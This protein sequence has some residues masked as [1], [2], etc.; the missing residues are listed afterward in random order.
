M[1]CIECMSADYCDRCSRSV[2][3]CQSVSLSLCLSRPCAWKTAKRSQVLVLNGSPDPTTARGGGWECYILPSAAVGLVYNSLWLLSKRV[4]SIFFSSNCVQYACGIMVFIIMSTYSLN[5]IKK[6]VFCIHHSKL[7]NA[8][9]DYNP[10]KFH[11]I[12][13]HLGSIEIQYK[14]FVGCFIE[15]VYT[16]NINQQVQISR[17]R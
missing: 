14:I 11:F 2:V 5:V 16:A 7:F 9:K 4:F 12:L 17:C 13:I 1:G 15:T 3:S 6:L 10:A 8:F